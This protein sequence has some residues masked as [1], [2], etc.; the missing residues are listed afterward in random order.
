MVSYIGELFAASYPE[1]IVFATTMNQ[2]L[3]DGL[4]GS[5]NLVLTEMNK[6]IAD[7]GSIFTREMNGFIN[8]GRMIMEGIGQGVTSRSSWLNSLVTSYVGL[9]PPPAE[10]V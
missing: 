4:S 6:L 8:I 9:I 3:A 1:F 10:S 5:K 2:T 7:I